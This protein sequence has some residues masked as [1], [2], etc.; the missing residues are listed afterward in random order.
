M[1][2]EHTNEV[3]V[4]DLNIEAGRVRVSPSAVITGLLVKSTET[5]IPGP[6]PDH[7][8]SSGLNVLREC[9][10]EVVGLLVH[11][12]SSDESNGI[13]AEVGLSTWEPIGLSEVGLVFELG[14]LLSSPVDTDETGVTVVGGTDVPA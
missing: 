7:G 9:Q 13:S 14:F 8:V 5:R 2:A 3:R 10:V 11:G 6:N 1:W 4:D 12:V